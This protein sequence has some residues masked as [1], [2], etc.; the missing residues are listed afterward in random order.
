MKCSTH[1]NSVPVH[2]DALVP[3][4]ALLFVGETQHVQEFVG[5]GGLVGELPK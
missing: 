1:V 3:V 4:W 2:V 5:S